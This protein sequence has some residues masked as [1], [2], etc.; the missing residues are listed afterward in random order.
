MTSKI[1]ASGTLPITSGVQVLAKPSLSQSVRQQ[2]RD[3]Q[4]PLGRF[5]M[6]MAIVIVAFYWRHT[7]NW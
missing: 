3:A 6:G 2:I 5:A 7:G 1:T 4:R